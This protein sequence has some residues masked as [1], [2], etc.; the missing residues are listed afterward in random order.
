MSTP[1]LDGI[2][3]VVTALETTGARVYYPAP[4][5]PVPPCY[6]IRDELA[7][8]EP[9]AIGSASWAVNLTIESFS[10]SKQIAAGHTKAA[11]M[12]WDAMTAL[13]TI[14]SAR[15]AAAPR[16]VDLDA[17]GSAMAAALSITINIKE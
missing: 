4:T 6:V 9:A 3:D 16:I 8:Y 13:A 5:I 10:D 14:S 2:A 12:Q 1:I 7:W 17:Q 11:E 15:Q